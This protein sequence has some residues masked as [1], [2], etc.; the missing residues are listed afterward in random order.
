MRKVRYPLTA[1]LLILSV[2]NPPTA[3]ASCV[4]VICG[5]YCGVESVDFCVYVWGGDETNACKSVV[6]RGC[7]SMRSLTCCPRVPRE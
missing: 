5:G 6:G 2:L 4:G 3:L 7:M 1:V